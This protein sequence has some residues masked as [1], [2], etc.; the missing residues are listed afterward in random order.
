ME[1]SS[2]LEVTHMVSSHTIEAG[3]PNV[4][5]ARKRLFALTLEKEAY[6]QWSAIHAYMTKRKKP[7]YLLVCHHD[8]P[9]YPHYHCLY[10][11][12]NPKNIS[13]E[14]L[15]GA[16]IEE[17][18]WSPQKYVDYCKGLDE[19]HQELGV[20]CR[21]VLEEGELKKAGGARMTVEE[22]KSVD[23]NQV[24]S[25]MYKVIKQIQ[26]D[27]RLEKQRHNRYIKDPDV[28]WHFG[29]TGSGKTYYPFIH[30][31]ENCEEDGTKKVSDWGDARK[32]V[33]E[34]FTGSMPYDTLKRMCDKYHNYY[35]VRVLYGEKYVDFDSIW[36]A[37]PR[38]P[39]SIYTKQL[40]KDESINQLMRRLNWVVYEHK[41]VDDHYYIRGHVWNEE[42][43]CVDH[44]TEWHQCDIIDDSDIDFRALIGL[45]D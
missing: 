40:L 24:P 2:T 31:Y 36:I 29:Q 10:Q 8:G 28:Q 18:V 32:I 3:H 22:A 21:I 1:Q 34:E 5:K 19:K 35:K 16:H 43:S 14:Y 38:P 11:Y 30:G 23:I 44:V 6:N 13:S 45:N 39:W 25:M 9:N 7:T 37:G 4:F 27:D 15:F 41:R 26:S 12:D 42:Q 20:N 17:H 33:F